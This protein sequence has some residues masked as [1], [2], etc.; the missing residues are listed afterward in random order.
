MLFHAGFDLGSVFDKSLELFIIES[1]IFVKLLIH[2]FLK[3]FLLSVH[4]HRNGV[5]SPL[6]LIVLY[7]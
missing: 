1:L 7:V 3:F 4:D 5:F 6:T 2:V